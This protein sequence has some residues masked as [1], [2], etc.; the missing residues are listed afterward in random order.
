[1][2]VYAGSIIGLAELVAMV[3]IVFA[4]IF[5]IGSPNAETKAKA[6]VVGIISAVALIVLVQLGKPIF[7]Q[8]Q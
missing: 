5:A 1:M 6:S 4:F 3:M 7:G 2:K 8:I